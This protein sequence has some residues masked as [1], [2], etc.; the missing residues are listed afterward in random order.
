MTTTIADLTE[1]MRALRARFEELVDE[2][3]PALWRYCLRLTGSA[4]DA[5]DLL[6]ETIL[7]AFGRLPNFW[8]QI[9][10]RPYLFR[11]AT[12]CWIDQVRR[13]RRF[14]DQPGEMEE[15]GA[16]EAD[17]AEAREALETV[18]FHLPPRQR[19]VFLLAEAFDFRAQ[20]IAGMIGTTEG[21][22]K[23]ALHRARETLRGV[24]EA[25]AAPAPGPERRAALL[26]VLHLYRDAFNRRDPD[27]IAALLHEQVA[28]DIVGVGEELGRE[29]A[30]SASLAEWAADPIP[31]WAEVGYLENRPTLFVY[32]RTG[33]SPRALAWLITMDADA[34]VV[35]GMRLY[36]FCPELIRHA[37]ER[38]GEDC[39][40]HGYHYVPP[41]AGGGAG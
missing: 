34:D 8:Q 14:G 7:R 30:R 4:W 9:D 6:Q 22:V 3:R 39:V 18:V 2:H 15:P 13:S 12:N 20:E 33:R 31:Q 16:T 21:A 23:A 17:G 26:P 1:P 40:T 5:E 35:T 27:A 28:V 19:V 36:Y 24:R 41:A 32:Y 10:A 11:I 29:T 37:A 38:L 25:G